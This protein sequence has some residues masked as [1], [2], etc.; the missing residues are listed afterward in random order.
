M[1]RLFPF[2]KWPL[3]VKLFTEEAACY[4]IALASTLPSSQFYVPSSDTKSR[5]FGDELIKEQ[6]HKNDEM[7]FPPGFTFSIELNS[8]NDSRTLPRSRRKGPL[9]ISDGKPIF[10]DSRK[11]SL[12][13]LYLD[14][15][16]V[17]PKGG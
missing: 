11:T 7:L 14:F 2:S 3:H 17:R 9:R 5:Q 1:V 12:D 13:M 4:W 10:F 15:I 8:V 16:H 6:A